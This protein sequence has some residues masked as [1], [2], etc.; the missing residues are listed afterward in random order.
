MA[1]PPSDYDEMFDFPPLA[2][3]AVA[4][5]FTPTPAQQAVIDHRDGNAVVL[6][7]AGS[8]KTSAMARRAIALL[9]DGVAPT[10]ILFLTFTRRVM[11]TMT[12][13]LQQLLP[14]HGISV[15]T[16][17]SYSYEILRRYAY[18]DVK[19][20]I[21][22]NKDGW[23][24]ASWMT[25]ASH[26][27]GYD[28]RPAVERFW[29][30]GLHWSR[31][32]EADDLRPAEMESELEAVQA[33]YALRNQTD[34]HHVLVDELTSF[35]VDV[36]RR[37]PDVLQRCRAEM[38]H[39]L[40]DEYQ[41]ID[42]AQEALLELLCG[43]PHPTFKYLPR[44]KPAE[45]MAIGDVDQSLYAFRGAE[46]AL[47]LNFKRKWN[48][49]IFRMQENFR[50]QEQIV[51]A[52][53]TLIAHNVERHAVAMR[54][55]R[56]AA[57][58]VE[59]LRHARAESGADV[60]VARKQE[61]QLPWS[62]L[63]VLA[64][65]NAGLAAYELALSARGI[66]FRVSGNGEGGF[67]Q[68]SEIKPIVGYLRLA[69][70]PT[71]HAALLTVWNRP[72]RYLKAE[73][74]HRLTEQVMRH[75]V[76]AALRT[77]CSTMPSRNAAAVSGLISIITMLQQLAAND[78]VEARLLATETMEATNYPS[79]LAQ[80]AAA[81]LRPTSQAEMAESVQRLL[82]SMRN[83]SLKAWLARIDRAQDLRHDDRDRDIDAVQL[84]TVHKAKGLEFDSVLV[85]EWEDEVMPHAK[86]EA[87]E[88]RRIAY[89][90]MTR[91]KNRLYLQCCG[92]PSPYS[93][94]IGL[95]REEPTCRSTDSTA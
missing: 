81:K 42:H 53:N 67:F 71:N 69:A 24:A 45:L 37:R 68:L 84:L 41:D 74:C 72:T 2:P 75:G 18:P 31:I 91:A 3:R 88:E 9:H 23:K 95:P 83:D 11:E 28:V 8:G 66:P 14:G 63:A 56:G 73:I 79:I 21:L 48:A 36:L 86:G 7:V 87:E 60:L 33:F 78:A 49:V 44:D 55:M 64:R 10:R 90:A 70:E 85:T 59:L 20:F 58:K 17:D 4:V 12:E 38:T 30:R 35:A 47:M 50:S 5:P 65:T 52:A 89:V 80:I 57:G 32:A 1:P 51:V 61:A 27:V 92:A 54:A 22:P 76:V 34:G 19:R 29:S 62:E 43:C 6:A 15:R 46:P 39:V 94:E 16:V 40:I 26:R 93:L 82:D 25:A 13:R 77:A